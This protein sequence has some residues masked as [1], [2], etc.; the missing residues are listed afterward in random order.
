MFVLGIDIPDVIVHNINQP[1]AVIDLLD[2]EWQ[3]RRPLVATTVL[4]WNPELHHT[5][6]SEGRAR[7]FVF[8][9]AAQFSSLD[10]HIV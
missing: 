10:L 2:A 6:F 3:S 4:S 7:E 8:S 9:E 5:R 1:D